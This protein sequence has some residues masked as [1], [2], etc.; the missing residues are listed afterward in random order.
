MV[1]TLHSGTCHNSAF[2]A[3]VYV[4]LGK[5]IMQSSLVRLKILILFPSS[6]M[7]VI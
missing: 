1:V 5:E 7:T 6:T 4:S 3:W 2:R